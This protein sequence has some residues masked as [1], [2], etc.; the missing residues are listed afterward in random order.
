M[1]LLTIC[2]IFRLPRVQLGFSTHLYPLS[3]LVL[4]CLW[5]AQVD[6]ALLSQCLLNEGSTVRR[7]VSRRCLQRH[8][9]SELRS[10][11]GKN[12]GSFSVEV[13]LSC[14]GKSPGSCDTLEM[15]YG[16][17]ADGPQHRGCIPPRS[18]AWLE[19]ANDPAETASQLLCSVSIAQLKK[20]SLEGVVHFFC[21]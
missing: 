20:F 4:I 2:R 9:A 8:S 5:L 18:A 21:M 12:A 17:A 3:R 19:G 7:Q 11:A 15:P 16:H 13:S 1:T 6:S 14:P 10:G